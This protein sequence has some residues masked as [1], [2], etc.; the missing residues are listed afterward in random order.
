MLRKK[1]FLC[2]FSDGRSP[3]VTWLG[4]VQVLH[5]CATP[6]QA[7][8][9]CPGCR[10]HVLHDVTGPQEDPTASGQRLT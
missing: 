2:R 8:P 1:L 6:P 10:E 5:S 4:G 7:C 9:M 3:M